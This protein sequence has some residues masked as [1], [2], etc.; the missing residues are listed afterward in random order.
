MKK[1]RV[2]IV[3]GASSGIGLSIAKYLAAK[4][5]TVYGAARSKFECEGINYSQLDVTDHSAVK[6][7][8]ADVFSREGRIDILVNNAGMGISGAI[9]STEIEKVEKIFN[10]NYFGAL[11]FCQAV[12]PHMRDIKGGKI[13]NICSVASII[14]LPFQSFYSSTKAAL[15][16]LTEALRMELK[17]F[18]V[19]ACAILPGDVHT[20]FTDSREKN[21][22]DAEVYGDKIKKSVGTMEH[23]ERNGMSPKKVAKAVYKQLKKRNPRPQK[24]VGFKYKIL[25]LLMKFLPRR[26]VLWAVGKIY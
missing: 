1:K 7:F 12:I 16:S 13:V 9:E 15:L 23:D 3:T 18:G 26:F 24:V 6:A 14:G 21:K 10:T 17:P 11:Y 19:K 4:G 22:H 2:A 25:S 8:V 5:C 20:G